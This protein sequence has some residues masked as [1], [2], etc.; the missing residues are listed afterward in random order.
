MTL[1]RQVESLYK[2]EEE[3]KIMELVN[4]IQSKLNQK[5]KQVDS[6]KQ[7]CT[8]LETNLETMSKDKEALS[9]DK[10]Q[11]EQELK[12]CNEKH[13]CLQ[14]NFKKIEHDSVELRKK[15]LKYEKELSNSN[16][17]YETC[18]KK[19]EILKN[20]LIKIKNFLSSLLINDGLTNDDGIDQ[21]EDKNLL[22]S[23]LLLILGSKSD[24]NE[25]KASKLDELNALFDST[26]IES[27]SN[28]IAEEEKNDTFDMIEE[29]KNLH[30]KIESKLSAMS[31]LGVNLIKG[32]DGKS[33]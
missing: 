19:N 14:K 24:R 30:V 7:K 32:N 31:E 22:L 20:D 8:Q 2:N 9:N 23:R 5:K 29:N 21:N 16:E 1:L 27:S 6:L 28:N 25:K 12:A 10:T 18:E 3:K 13:E 4:T 33:I 11:L 17:K 26:L 15:I